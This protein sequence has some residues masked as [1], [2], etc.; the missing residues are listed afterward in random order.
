[1]T[2]SDTWKE[3]KLS[4]GKKLERIVQPSRESKLSH[5]RVE[6]YGRKKGGVVIEV[7]PCHLVSFN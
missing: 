4:R 3:W 6:K 5:D 7:L 1:M 2:I